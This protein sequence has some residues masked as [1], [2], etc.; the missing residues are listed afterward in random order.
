MKSKKRS[1]DSSVGSA[2]ARATKKRF[3]ISSHVIR[4]I[5]IAFD[6]L[7]ILLSALISY[8]AII[9]FGE[10]SYYAAATAFVW[11]V[12]IMLMNFAG[13]YEFEATTR[14]FVFI[15]KIFI[16]FAT[17]FSFLLAAA[18]ALKISDQFSR[19]WTG[20]FALSVCVT[21]LI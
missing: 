13:L 10:P 21:T 6:S 5:I 8:N 14:P 16:V 19:I 18:F 2:S 12:T 7:T 15:D 3:S 20:T 4:G 9:Y 1:Q 11:L 17:T